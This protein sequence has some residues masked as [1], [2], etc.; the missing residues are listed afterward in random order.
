M[1]AL[2]LLPRAL[3]SNETYEVVV[4]MESVFNASLRATGYLL[5]RVQDTDP[6]LIGIGLVAASS[7]KLTERV[8]FHLPL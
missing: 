7:H 3:A 1:S 4:H 8:C 6:Q 2:T 5:V